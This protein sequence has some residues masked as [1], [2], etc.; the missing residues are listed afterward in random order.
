[1]QSVLAGLNPK[2]GPDFVSVYIDDILVFS[3]YLEEHLKHLQVVISKVNKAGLKFK[4]SKCHFIK[5]D[6][7]FLGHVITANGLQPNPAKI[8]VVR[9]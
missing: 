3:E 2:N 7:D 6:I 8:E 5:K 9:N 1:M 4:P